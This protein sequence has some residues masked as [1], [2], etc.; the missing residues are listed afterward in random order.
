[1]QS[2][3][4]FLRHR[5]EFRWGERTPFFCPPAPFSVSCPQPAITHLC[6]QSDQP[7]MCVL[8]PSIFA[9]LAAATK[10]G[11][12]EAALKWACCFLE[13]N[14][15]FEIKRGGME[16]RE[17]SHGEHS[18]SQISATHNP[19]PTARAHAQWH[20]YGFVPPHFAK[21]SRERFSSK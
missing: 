11:R 3:S 12:G 16:G 21:V 1:M 4:N 19:N 9:V 7:R 6:C 2:G 18:T 14:N 8:L 13:V 17:T 10:R 15:T 20:F 5:R